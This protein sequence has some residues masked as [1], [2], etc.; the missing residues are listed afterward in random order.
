MEDAKLTE[1][2]ASSNVQ[3]SCDQR[4]LV[5]GGSVAG[6]SLFS[7]EQLRKVRVTEATLGRMS[8]CPWFVA[9]TSQPRKC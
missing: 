3:G 5:W 6:E 9:L 8:V 1:L 7:R 2:A 4:R